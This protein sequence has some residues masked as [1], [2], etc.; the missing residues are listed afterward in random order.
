MDPFSLGASILGVIGLTIQVGEILVKFGMDWTYAPDDVKH[1]IMEIQTLKTTLST[2]YT[3]AITNPEFEKAM[4]GTESALLSHFKQK[5]SDSGQLD[6]PMAMCKERLQKLLAEL[7]KASKGSKFGWSRL[8]MAFL[9]SDIREA[10]E[11]LHCQCQVLNNL[12]GIDS[13]TLGVETLKEIRAVRQEANE[14]RKARQDWESRNDNILAV[15]KDEQD[16]RSQTDRLQELSRFLKLI[17]AS[18]YASEQRDYLSKRTEGTGRWLLESETYPRWVEGTGGTFFCSGMPGSG[19]TIMSSIVTDNLN[20]RIANLPDIYLAFIYCNFRRQHEQSP[21]NILSSILRQLIQQQYKVPDYIKSLYSRTK[22]LPNLS[23]IANALELCIKEFSKGYVVIDALD[24][25][26]TDFGT[27]K[28]LL[29]ELNKIQIKTG[30]NL[31]VTTRPM[32]EPENLF[33]KYMQLEIRADDV[34]V[35]KYVHSRLSDL[36]K[37]VEADASLQTKIQS[38]IVKH[39]QGM[40]VPSISLP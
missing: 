28:A 7:R 39:V 25:L 40:Y 12:I 20:E 4:R 14:D 15:L 16:D 23:Q 37:Y 18:D 10:V 5:E 24:E 34:D 9:A 32:Y 22:T 13:L 11:D 8:K 3:N 33:D 17:S 21:G 30:L 29:K 27:L 19:K 6:F 31:F 36:P 38:T 35:E 26:S 2:T 1:F